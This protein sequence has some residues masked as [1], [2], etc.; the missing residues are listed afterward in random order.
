MIIKII[1]GKVF[2]LINEE[3]FLGAVLCNLNRY[4]ESISCFDLAIEINP[5]DHWVKREPLSSEVHFLPPIPSI[6]P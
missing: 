4:T 5:N 6:P 2:L 3:F 1:W